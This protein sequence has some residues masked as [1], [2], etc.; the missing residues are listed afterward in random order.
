[1]PARA[2]PGIRIF[3]FCFFLDNAAAKILGVDNVIVFMA[4]FGKIETKA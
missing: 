4:S 1:M 3:F 2:A